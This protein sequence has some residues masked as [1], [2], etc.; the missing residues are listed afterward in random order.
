M[1]EIIHATTIQ[2]LKQ[3]QNIPGI[4]LHDMAFAY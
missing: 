3:E 4:S 1:T 2:N